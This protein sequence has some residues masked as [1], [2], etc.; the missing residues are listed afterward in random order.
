[1]ILYFGKH[2]EEY[3]GENV[4]IRKNYDMESEIIRALKKTDTV[5][6]RS[7]N[8]SFPETDNILFVDDDSVYIRV[9]KN[10]K[11]LRLIIKHIPEC[12][13]LDISIDNDLLID[14][15]CILKA[16]KLKLSCNQYRF[17]N[18]KKVTSNEARIYMNKNFKWSYIDAYARVVNNILVIYSQPQPIE[19]I[20]LKR[21]D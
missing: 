11:L 18:K 14:L 1:M 7:T 20:L 12:N 21:L 17:S 6:I 15:K 13:E 10:P 9:Y 4:I 5:T 3:I 16:K 19:F 8:E 2:L